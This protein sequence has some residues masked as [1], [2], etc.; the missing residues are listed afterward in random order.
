MAGRLGTQQP[1]KQSNITAY[2]T[3]VKRNPASKP[4][5]LPQLNSATAKRPNPMRSS[6]RP[7]RFLAQL[8]VTSLECKQVHPF[9]RDN[10]GT[11]DGGVEVTRSPRMLGVQGSNPIKVT[12]GKSRGTGQGREKDTIYLFSRKRSALEIA[13]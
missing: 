12:N 4:H 7:D 1:A 3:T 9:G 10:S 11:C 8:E 6:G 5:C 2:T 13:T